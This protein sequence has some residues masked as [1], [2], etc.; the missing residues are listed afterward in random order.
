MRGVRGAVVLE[1]VLLEAFKGHDAEEPCGHD[2]VGVE[3]VAAK[4]KRAPPDGRDG[5]HYAWTSSIIV[6]TS[7]TSPTTAAAATMAG[8]MSSVRPVG[9]PWRPLKLRLDDEAQTWRPSSRAGFIARHIE[10]PAPRHSKPAFAKIWSSPFASAARLTLCE[11]GTTSALT[12]G[13][14]RRPRTSFAASSRSDRR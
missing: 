8:L 5:G 13:A 9:L 11:P 3:V 2:A 7:T 14:T 12:C 10:H 1:D 4:R 6:R